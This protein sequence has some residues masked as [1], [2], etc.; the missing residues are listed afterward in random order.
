M[1][2]KRYFKLFKKGQREQQPPE[3]M[4]PVNEEQV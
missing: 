4:P 1:A 2:P 3:E